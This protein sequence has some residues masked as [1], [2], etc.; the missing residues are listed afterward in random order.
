MSSL[1]IIIFVLALTSTFAALTAQNA[2]LDSLI[3]QLEQHSNEDIVRVNLLNDIAELK[4]SNEPEKS[5]SYAK[6]A[7]ELSNKLNFK[8]G[9]ARS[10]QIIGTYNYNKYDYP[11]ALDYYQKSLNIS[12]EIEDKWGIAR[13]YNRIGIIYKNQGNYPLALENYFNSLKIKEELEDRKGIARSYNNIGI[14]YYHQ[15]NYPLALEYYF[16]SLKI[17]E[18]LGDRSGIAFSNNIIGIIYKNQGNYPLAL[19][20]Y[21]KSLKINE[22]LEDR[23][24]IAR[25]YNNIGIIYKNQGNYPLAL[26]YYFKSLKINEELGNRSG[27]ASNYTNIGVIYRMQGNNPLALEYS[28]KSLKINEE[29][30]NKRGLS[31]AYYSIGMCYMQGSEIKKGIDY[32]TRALKLAQSINQVDVIKGSAGELSQA[33][34]KIKQFDRAYKYLLMFKEKSDELKN[35]E[36][37][38]KITQMEMQYEFDKEKQ[39]IQL[40]QVKKDALL[41]A[42]AKQQS[43]IRNSFIAGFILMSL[44]VLLVWRSL[45]QRRKANNL[46]RTQA[47]ELKTQAVQL[48]QSRQKAEVANQAKSE[49]LANMSHEIRTPLNAVLGFS[50]ILSMQE[51]DSKKKGYLESI[52]SSGKSLLSL[53]ND[54]LDLSKI[55]AGKLELNYSAVSIQSMFDEMSTIFQHSIHDK[56]VI[57]EID[58]DPNLPQSLLLDEAR[59]RQVLMNLLGNAVKFTEHGYIRLSAQLKEK[60]SD[61]KSRI[62]LIIEVEDSGDGISKED[63]GLIFN[64]FEQVKGDKTHAVGTGLGLAISKNILKVMNGDISVKSVEGQGSTFRIELRDVEVTVKKVKKLKDGLEFKAN[65]LT[66]APAKVLIVDDIAYNRDVLAAYLTPFNFELYFAENGRIG[67]EKAQRNRPDLILMDMRMPEMDGYEATKYLKS[68]D[69]G[70][71]PPVIAVTA[72]AFRQ[73]KKSIK[74]ICDGYLRK[75]LDQFTLINEMKKHL[76]YSEEKISVSQEDKVKEI[77]VPSQGKLKELYELALDGNMDRIT[78]YLDEMLENDEKLKGFCENVRTLALGYKDEEIV[79]LVNGYIV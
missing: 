46:L 61:I 15:G 79:D 59:L 7:L 71:C 54:V 32:S 22:E 6:E 11:I 51:E 55:E 3:N 25:S 67:I 44:L 35:E 13:S 66:F 16:K 26:E 19:E 21:F 65:E 2:Q 23:K 17:K 47:E 24:G 5:L 63:Q 9:K 77:V 8:K 62:M 37:T 57:F 10:L 76:K 39:T 43:I 31:Y 68:D 56:G 69:Y 73:D 58:L 20:Y 64:E 18:E 28:F 1:K 12:E 48:R 74:L 70:D 33:Y 30:G 34:A 42:E 40:E 36:K 53:I 38:K 72:S 14:V 41:I 45:A 75:P 29:L 27:I 60:E 52:Q 50:E 78:S 49:F 4:R